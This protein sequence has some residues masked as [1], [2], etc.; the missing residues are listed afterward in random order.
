VV[1][2]AVGS[3]SSVLIEVSVDVIDMKERDVLREDEEEGGTEE[4][5]G[6]GR[7]SFAKQAEKE[8]GGVRHAHVV[9]VL[10]PVSFGERGGEGGRDEMGVL[11][12]GEEDGGREEEEREE[13]E[14]KEHRSRGEVWWASSIER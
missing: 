12:L 5:K 14:G 11:S 4:R 2:R 13:G 10:I 1:L 7:V 6:R 3:G 9:S 8:E